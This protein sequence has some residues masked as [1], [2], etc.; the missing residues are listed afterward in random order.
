M[1]TSPTEVQRGVTLDSERKFGPLSI[2]Q[3]IDGPL[4]TLV[5]SFCVSVK[6]PKADLGLLIELG[7]RL[8]PQVAILDKIAC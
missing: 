2:G 3:R 4:P 8:H 6:Q 1:K 5:V 7:V